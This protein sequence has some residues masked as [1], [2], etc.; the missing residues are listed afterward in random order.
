MAVSRTIRSSI[1]VL[2]LLGAVRSP[3]SV[4]GEEACADGHLGLRWGRWREPVTGVPYDPL[5]Y[6]VVEAEPSVTV[7][8]EGVGHDCKLPKEPV[9]GTYEVR[10]YPQEV[11]APAT[12]VLDYQPVLPESTGPVYGSDGP[13][14][15]EH[16]RE[17]VISQDLLPEAVAEQAQAIIT[18]VS[19]RADIPWDVPLQIIDDDGPSRVAFNSGERRDHSE[20]YPLSV[21]VLRAGPADASDSFP[22]T[23]EGSGAVPA[24]ADDF[25][26]V[27]PEPLVFAP[28]ERVKP[29]EIA[30]VND[31]L[32]E[33]TEELTITLTEPGLLT[34]DAEDAT[35]VTVRI[36][37]NEEGGIGAPPTSKFHHPRQ[38]LHYERGDYRLRE[39]HVFARDEEGEVARVEI[40]VRQN[41]LR[42]GCAWLTGERFARAP[43]SA[44]RW[45]ETGYYPDLDWYYYRMVSLKPSEGTAIKSYTAFARATDGAGN[46]EGEFEVGRNANTFEVGKR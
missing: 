40:A 1:V 27:T 7:T 20:T 36:L 21:L 28:G 18:P 16:A 22:F 12:A 35:T 37:D 8:V 14:P 31:P 42:G 39:F 5:F 13:P 3:A 26:V 32:I 45:L 41:R 33:P 43:C 30:I 15:T 9:T 4:S 34:P 6:W 17:V 2:T 19:G 38:R 10:D 24:S 46:V 29:I 23:V 44:K 11:P 25:E